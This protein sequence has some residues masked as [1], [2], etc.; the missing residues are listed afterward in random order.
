MGPPVTIKNNG[1][2]TTEFLISA[3]LVLSSGIFVMGFLYYFSYQ[4][5]SQYHAYQALL[6]TVTA[7]KISISLGQEVSSDFQKDAAGKGNLTSSTDFFVAKE[8]KSKKSISL[9]FAYADSVNDPEPG[10]L[11]NAMIAIN[12]RVKILANK[13]QLTY[14]NKV[15]IYAPTN[16][17]DREDTSFQSALKVA[18]LLSL[19]YKDKGL[20]L[21]LSF[22]P[23]LLRNFHQYSTNFESKYNVEYS[24]GGVLA[25]KYDYT[26][27]ISFNLSGTS[28]LNR[29][30]NGINKEKFA[31][32]EE[33]SFLI[34]KKMILGLG[35]RNGGST[36]AVDG[37]SNVGIYDKINS[38]F[39][40]SLMYSM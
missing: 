27:K 25:A 32:A 37:S 26:E 31:L 24:F 30:Y 23:S 10:Q 11:T 16:A 3:P 7:S 29:T 36:V 4:V 17:Q 8:L 33:V 28:S 13:K 34:N 21:V 18:S 14:V 9:A 1:Q 5:A 12:D 35:H 20:P 6:C 22:T 40:A 15:A 2:S 38:E 39:Y 19:S